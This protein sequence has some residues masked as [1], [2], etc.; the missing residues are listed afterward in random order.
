MLQL[1]NSNFSPLRVSKKMNEF[2]FGALHVKFTGLDL[3]NRTFDK[4]EELAN[5]EWSKK[6]NKAAGNHRHTFRVPNLVKMLFNRKKAFLFKSY[7]SSYFLIFPNL[8]FFIFLQKASQLR[9][10]RLF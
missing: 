7:S 10:K 4:I 3:L 9:L 2:L 1:S 5:E 8:I 6:I